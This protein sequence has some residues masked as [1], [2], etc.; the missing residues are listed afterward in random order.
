[1]IFLK[2]SSNKFILAKNES[3]S[4]FNVSSILNNKLVIN[5]IC[6]MVIVLFLLNKKSIFALYIVLSIFKIYFQ[7]VINNSFIIL[8]DRKTSKI[9]IIS[10]TIKLIFS[11]ISS[12]LFKS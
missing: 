3:N 7:E 12:I 1:M 5:R 8:Y 9:L 4:L 2:F 10:F 11:T 6:S